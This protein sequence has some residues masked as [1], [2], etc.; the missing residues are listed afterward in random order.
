[1]TPTHKD[2]TNP[3]YSK[4]RTFLRE[5][6]RWPR[7]RIAEFELSELR[8]ILDFAY[9]NTAGYK[10]LFDTQGIT[11]INIDALEDIRNFPFIT[12]E[13]IRD[14]VTAFSADVPDRFYV[15][16]GGSTGIPFGMYRDP[17][18]FAK[19]LASKAHQ[20]HRIGWREGDRQIVF[21]GLPINTPDH[22]EY[23]PELNE[24]RC[25]TYEFIPDVLEYYVN[26][27]HEYQ[28]EWLR[29]YPSA[30]FMLASFIQRSGLKFPKLKGILCASEMLFD[31]QKNLMQEVF[32]TRIFSHYGHYELAALAGFCEFTDDYH[33]MPQ[34][35]YVELI[36]ESGQSITEAGKTGEIVAT[37]FI[38]TATPFIRYRTGDM[39]VLKGFGCEKC[40]RPYQI[41]E[42]VIG[43]RQEMIMS[44]AG[45][46]I[47]TTM[48]NMHDDIYDHIRQYQ[49]AQKAAGSVIFRYVPKESMTDE[50]AEDM[51]RRLRVKLGDD[52][53]VIMEPVSNITLTKRGKHRALVQE[54]ESPIGNEELENAE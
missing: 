4:W 19:E 32:Q 26:R 50:I 7:N 2:L 52:M 17:S 37:S 34:Y 24:L 29:C 39:A 16:T 38:S 40:H 42:K 49:F 18:A 45:R 43:R 15:T 30:G 46:L 10:G 22:T 20:Y 13:L 33:V 8:R 53:T 48:L 44:K 54:M 6:E 28:P 36:D 12:K 3:D 1:M 27:A 35:G 31:F 11:S 25:S 14:N 5:S 41:W 51:K 21:R 9:D 23:I 47:S